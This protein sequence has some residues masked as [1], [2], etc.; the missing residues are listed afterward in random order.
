MGVIPSEVVQPLPFRPIGDVA[1]NDANEAI[2]LDTPT[3]TLLRVPAW[4]TEAILR[5]FVRELTGQEEMTYTVTFDRRQRRARLAFTSREIRDVVA[6]TIVS[7]LIHPPPDL[8]WRAYY[9]LAQN[10]NVVVHREE[11]GD[12]VED[13]DEEQDGMDAMDANDRREAQ[14]RAMRRSR[15]A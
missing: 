9:V 10:G 11:N 5:D 6:R 7:R 2:G 12:D 13:P 1:P 14:V 4:L 3:T 8:V 15:W